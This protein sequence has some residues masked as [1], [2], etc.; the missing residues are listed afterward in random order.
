MERPL[1]IHLTDL[2]Q[3]SASAFRHALRIA[4]AQRAS[5]RLVHVHRQDHEAAASFDA[6]PHVRETLARWGLLAAGAPT[7]AVAEQLGLHVS[8]LEVGAVRP[9]PGVETLVDHADPDLI[10]L[11][12]REQSVRDAMQQGSFAEALARHVRTPA[13]IVPSGAPGFV[14][15]ADGAVSL[16]NILMPVTSRPEQGLPLT[17]VARLVNALHA[18]ARLILLHVGPEGGAPRLNL[19]QGQRYEQ[20]VREGPVV[21]AIV[22]A[23]EATAA[24]LIVMATEGHRSLPDDLHGD[25]CEHVLRRAHRPLLAVPVG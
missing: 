1:I 17:I 11:G 22:A 5:L 21:D 14:G 12:T 8:K 15:E 25:T 23:A 16:K 19:P 20:M 7:A 3:A 6:F 9:E 24:D 2:G 18:D 13:L 4:L 10:V